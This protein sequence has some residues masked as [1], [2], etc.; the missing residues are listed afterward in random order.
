MHSLRA[1]LFISILLPV[2]VIV[3]I[4]ALAIN[5]LLQTQVVLAGIANEL[6]RQAVLVAEASITS[7]EIWQ[8]PAQAQAFAA[9]ISP[10]LSAKL[11]LFDPQGRL[12]VSSDARDA[13]F[14]GK[15][16]AMPDL[17]SLLAKEPRAEVRYYGTQISDVI[18][19][20]VSRDGQLV[21][22]VWLTN[23]LAG[24]YARSELLGRITLWVSLAGVIGGLLLGLL[25][26]RDVERPLKNASR[27]VYQLAEGGAPPQTLREEGPGEVRLLARAFNTLLDR[28]HSSEE[29]RRRQLANTVHELGRP[30]G[31]LLSA[32]QALNSG[33][34]KKPALRAE[35]LQGMEREVRT[36]RR[37]LDDLA[38]L[39]GNAKPLELE[40]QPVT[41]AQWLPPLLAPWGE[42]AQR[43]GLRWQTHI[44]PDLPEAVFDPQRIGQALGNLI[45]NAIRYTPSGGEVEVTAEA[46]EGSLLLRVR[47]SGKGIPPEELAFIFEPFYRGR[48]VRHNSDGMGLGLTIA[49]EIAA[50]HG[51]QLTAESTPAQGSTFTLCL[52]LT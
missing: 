10:R 3:P 48:E 41:V 9:R 20:V 12:V 31:A 37:M 17:Q 44:A 47:D 25:L 39:E 32:I 28:L 40:R 16:Y 1:R 51:G 33:A 5:F 15:V 11:M 8:D 19:P 38:R 13:Q 34:V 24:L 23:P 26:A 36:L 2:L 14:V 4:V 6:I 43:K 21:G 30:L 42:E 18:V 52:P 35:L 46:A 49:R 29:L 22:F 50:A 7:V 45:S 27:A